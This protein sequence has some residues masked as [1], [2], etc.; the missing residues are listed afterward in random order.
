[1]RG[2]LI[3]ATI[4]WLVVLAIVV[5]LLW[6]GFDLGPTSKVVGK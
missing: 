5:Y 1:M 4:A 3:L 6:Q 2:R